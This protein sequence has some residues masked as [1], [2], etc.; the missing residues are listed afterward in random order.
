MGRTLKSGLACH[1]PHHFWLMFMFCCRAWTLEGKR[2]QRCRVVHPPLWGV[3]SVRYWRLASSW[4]R[5]SRNS[6]APRK[7]FVASR[8]RPFFSPRTHIFLVRLPLARSWTRL[9]LHHAYHADRLVRLSQ[10]G[11]SIPFHHSF[12]AVGRFVGWHYGLQGQQR[13]GGNGS[14]ERMSLAGHLA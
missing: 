12:A 8:G 14:A 7:G 1:I 5:P 11:V 3:R 6:V 9:F 4:N 10:V 2:S 13:S